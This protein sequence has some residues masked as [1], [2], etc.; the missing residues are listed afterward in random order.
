MISEDSDAYLLTLIASGQAEDFEQ[1]MKAL[2]RKVTL[3]LQPR[4]N[5]GSKAKRIDL[6]LADNACANCDHIKSCLIALDPDP[7]GTMQ[8]SGRIRNVM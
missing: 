4:K 5:P 3:L 7:P 1:E 2:Q 6:Y 8:Q